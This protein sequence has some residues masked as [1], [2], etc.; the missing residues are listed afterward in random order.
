M[1]HEEEFFKNSQ[2]G[3]AVDTLIGWGA[4]MICGMHVYFEPV[5]AFGHS[6]HNFP[7]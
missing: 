6:T 3:I 2:W 7:R 5:A 1:D 4:D